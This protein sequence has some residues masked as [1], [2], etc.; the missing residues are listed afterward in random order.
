MSSDE[1]LKGAVG[2]WTGCYPCKPI[3]PTRS[4]FCDLQRLSQ[5]ATAGRSQHRITVLWRWASELAQVTR[6][7]RDR[8]L[9]ITATQKISATRTTSDVKHC[10]WC[11]RWCC[12][13]RPHCY[14][15]IPQNPE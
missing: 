12:D 11:C 8:V 14:Q 5:M 13:R 1:L 9:D 4:P 3:P 2:C 15:W 7:L 6:F 10:W